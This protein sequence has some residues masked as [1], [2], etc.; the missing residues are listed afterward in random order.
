[1]RDGFTLTVGDAGDP[2]FGFSGGFLPSRRTYELASMESIGLDQAELAG[3]ELHMMGMALASN[4][5]VFSAEEFIEAFPD[6]SM[7]RW[8]EVA[9]LCKTAGTALELVTASLCETDGMLRPVK[10]E[11]HQDP[12][13]PMVAAFLLEACMQYLVSVGHNLANIA[14]RLCVES[15]VC[16]AALAAGN[17]SVRKVLAGVEGPG[18]TAAWIYH[19]QAAKFLPC[20]D[21]L[22]EP[23]VICMHVV[24]RLYE[25]PHWREL[26]SARNEYHHRWREGFRG[27]SGSATQ[28][29]LE[30]QAA[31]VRAAACLG[32]AI[33][34]FYHRLL[35]SYPSS[36]TPVGAPLVGPIWNV[37]PKTGEM[38]LTLP[39]IPFES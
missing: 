19:S 31:T 22:R 9:E 4:L 11:S 10:D 24:A 3:G 1:M 15:V 18:G 29:A 37:D 28:S 8:V 17:A 12:V 25:A 38:T 20:L 33:P 32:R 36:T 23:A 14:L 13:S 16:R 26:S 35:D 39:D 2:W 34:E 30:L 6:Q 21:D 7:D 5:A 27:G